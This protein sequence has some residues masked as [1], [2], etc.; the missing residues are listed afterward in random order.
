VTRHQTQTSTG[1]A[2]K[3][4][5]GTQARI[6]GV[7]PLGPDGSFNLEVPADKFLH[8]QVLDSDNQVVGNQLIWMSVRPGEVRTC[9]GCH[10]QPGT[11]PVNRVFPATSKQASISCL[12]T[13]DNLSYRAKLWNKGS[14][15]DEEEERMRTV[16]AVNLMGR[17]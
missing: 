9:I 6:L 11:T 4:H 12:P 7:V 5:G 16:Q 2:W 17:N 8:L 14:I 1:L 13:E 10:E 15:S 3:N